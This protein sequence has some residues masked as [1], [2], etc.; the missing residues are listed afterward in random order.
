VDTTPKYIKQCERAEEIQNCWKAE[1]GDFV[2]IWGYSWLNNPRIECCSYDKFEACG[3][4]L[5]GDREIGS[6][7]VVWLPTQTQ[8]QK[9]VE[10]NFTEQGFSS[11]WGFAYT[12]IDDMFHA[13]W[14]WRENEIK[15]QGRGRLPDE[16]I[17]AEQL[18]LAFVMHEKYGKHWDN[19][20]EEW[21]K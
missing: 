15:T 10:W 16:S 18:W 11:G 6:Y 7:K 19:D 5:H 2:A 8:L 13:F 20:K 17:T 14:E 12:H 9:M 3:K 1:E 21:V 4:G